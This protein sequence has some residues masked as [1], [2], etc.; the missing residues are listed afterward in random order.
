MPRRRASN[1]RRSAK[2]PSR[3]GEIDSSAGALEGLTPEAARAVLRRLLDQHPEMGPEAQKIAASLAALP[4]LAEASQD[5]VA[6]A[7][8]SSITS[9]DLDALNERAGAHSWGYVEPSEAAWELLEEAIEEWI[10]DMKRQA[11]SGGIAAA[12]TTCLGIVQGLYQARKVQSDGALGWA[13]DFPAEAAGQAVEKLIQSCCP[14]VAQSTHDRL[15]EAF[16]AE[17]PEWTDGLSRVLDSA[18]DESA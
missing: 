17:V 9:I 10:E 7:V 11:G 2:P 3:S 14:E 15:L 1:P 8:F 12:E 6:K 13:P 4:P 5:D 18:S 16:R